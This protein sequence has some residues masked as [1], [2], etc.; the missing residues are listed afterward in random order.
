MAAANAFRAKS[1]S[2][3]GTAILG[4]TDVSTDESG[5]PT[6]LST[7]AS[8]TVTA[9]FVDQIAATVTVSTTDFTAAKGLLI[10]TAGALVIT[11]E[12]R[13]EGKGAGSGNAIATYANAI[14][15]QNPPQA[16]TNGIGGC[17]LSFRCSAPG[18][19]SPVVWS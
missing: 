14:L 8:A 11:Y 7:D 19:A 17:T 16:N 10:G 6:D 2:F 15:V 4:I 9:V 18:G 12:I 13:A 1:A 3:G 5:T